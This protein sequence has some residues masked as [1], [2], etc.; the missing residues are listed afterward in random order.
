MI[1]GLVLAAAHQPDRDGR[2]FQG[3]A[4]APA[5]GADGFGRTRSSSDFKAMPAAK[6]EVSSSGSRPRGRDQLGRAAVNVGAVTREV[7]GESM[8]TA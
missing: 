2:T 5:A 3:L 8:T 4:R 6:A 1:G 7:T